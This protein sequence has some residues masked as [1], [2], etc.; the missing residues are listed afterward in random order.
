VI[1]SIFFLTVVGLL[2]AVIVRAFWRARDPKRLAQREIG[3]VV[4]R[5]LRA[6]RRQF[7]PLLALAALLAP[8]GVASPLVAPLALQLIWPMQQVFAADMPLTPWIIVA[9]MGW[10]FSALSLGR[11]LLMYGAACAI[12]ESSGD[13]SP[14]AIWA[15]LRR[16]WRRALQIVSLMSLPSL[17]I[18]L[19]VA[20]VSETLVDIS[21][22]AVGLAVLSIVLGVPVFLMVAIII[23]VRWSLAP[24][25]MRCEA[26]GPLAAIKR[27][28]RLVR[29]QGSGSSNA[30]MALLTIGWLIVSTPAAG[31]LLLLRLAVALTPEMTTGFVILV[32]MIGSIFVAP[33]LALG[34]TEFYLYVRPV[35][36]E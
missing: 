34:A 13:Q 21:G 20:I 23:L 35:I 18:T 36:Q 26:L 31:A 7:V 6:Y 33:L 16:D 32:W 2:L 30:T 5:A 8:L 24:A 4:D 14:R 11:S 17:L 28:G 19:V 12:V 27:S 25:I 22:Q 9:R 15:A 3:V 1:F 29:S 10:C